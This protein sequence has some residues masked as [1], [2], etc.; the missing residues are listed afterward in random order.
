[1]YKDEYKECKSWRGRFNQYFIFGE[2]LSCDQWQEDNNNCF[3]WSWMEDKEA[4]IRLI[5]SELK[6]KANRIKVHLENDTWTKRD[7]TPSDWSKP[8][9]D[10]MVERNKNSYLERKCRELEAEEEKARQELLIVAKSP[11]GAKMPDSKNSFCT[12]M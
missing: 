9:P 10:F 6:R 11:A 3:R 2:T 1:M 7:N 8:L 4:A 12:F 5:E